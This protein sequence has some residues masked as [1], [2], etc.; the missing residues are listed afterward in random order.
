MEKI[1]FE[2][3]YNID[4]LSGVRDAYTEAI[5]ELERTARLY[6]RYI[7]Y[8]LTLCK[9]ERDEKTERFEQYTRPRNDAYAN[10]EY[11][12]YIH[13]LD[14]LVSKLELIKKYVV[15]HGTESDRIEAFK[16]QSDAVMLV[17]HDVDNFAYSNIVYV[18]RGVDLASAIKKAVREFLAT[19]EG[20]RYLH[21]EN[22]HFNYGDAIMIPSE[23]TIT[24]GYLIVPQVQETYFVNVDQNYSFVNNDFWE[25]YYAN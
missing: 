22:N 4:Y 16:Q 1:A 19:P 14:E 15:T 3:G 23:I 20:E 13:A 17:R 2:D 12:G 25:G 24:H 18:Q 9:K 7:D 21:G 11:S 8:I 6:K 5:D 10:G